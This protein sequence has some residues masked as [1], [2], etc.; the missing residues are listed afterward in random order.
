MA[1]ARRRLRERLQCAAGGVSARSAALCVG[2]H[3]LANHTLP[4][5]GNAHGTGVE[6]ALGRSQRTTQRGAIK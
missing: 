5:A 4:L 1:T 2:Q 3:L 6:E